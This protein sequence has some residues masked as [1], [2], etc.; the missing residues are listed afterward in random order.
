MAVF[1]EKVMSGKYR[2]TPAAVTEENFIQMFDLPKFSRM[3]NTGKISF[4][5]AK[6]LAAESMAFIYDLAGFGFSMTNLKDRYKGGIFP[7]MR[8][9]RSHPAITARG[10]TL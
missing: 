3:L 8:M 7:I 5:Q 9:L 2:W 6:L 10:L 4:L 1:A